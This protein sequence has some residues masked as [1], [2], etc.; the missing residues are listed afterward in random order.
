[1]HLRR[2]P[3][4]RDE[5]GELLEQVL[6]LLTAEFGILPTAGAAPMGSMAANT[7]FAIHALAV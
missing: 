1:M 6:L 2:I 7:V 3:I 5:L 4:E